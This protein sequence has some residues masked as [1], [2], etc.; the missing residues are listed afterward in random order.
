MLSTLYDLQK[1]PRQYYVT[2]LIALALKETSRKN[3]VLVEI[4]EGHK[5]FRACQLSMYLLHL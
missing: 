4:V 2:R 3:F 5:T 1:L